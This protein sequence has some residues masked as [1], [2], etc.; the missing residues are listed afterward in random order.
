MTD[1]LFIFRE[2]CG[3]EQLIGFITSNPGPVFSYDSEYLK[4]SNAKPIS[5]SL[6]LKQGEFT[7]KETRSFFEG[8]L[9]EGELRTLFA[10]TL[11]VEPE[12]YTK[13]ISQLNNESTGA[14]I[15]SKEKARPLSNQSYLPLE[16]RTLNEFAKQPKK[17][18]L[19]LGMR[20]RLSL[21]G[22]QAK[23]GLYHEG[24]D[25]SAG[26]F[27]PIGGAPSTHILKASDGTFPM[28]TINEAFC[29]R[30]AALCGLNVCESSLIAVKDSSD[31]ILI[32]ERFDR[33]RAERSRREDGHI[34]PF[35]LH[36]EDFCQASSL[37][38]MYK[39][40]PTDG[41]Y[42]SRVAHVIGKAS[43][44]PLEDRLKFFQGILFDYLIGNC[45]NHLKNYSLLWTEDWS[46][47]SLSPFYDKTCTTM[48]P[49]L[50]REMGISL[51]PSRVI[52]KVIESDIKASG[53]QIG[54]SESMS[55]S[56]YQKL[57]NSFSK[58]L[59]QA[60]LEISNQ[61]FPE[62]KELAEFIY[63]DAE[64]RLT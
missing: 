63:L 32:I 24:N 11:H 3:D 48:Y 4:N 6:P 38:S 18:T 41:Y 36:Q 16:S 61:G 33:V 7:Q 44:N 53:K 25:L 37:P 62:V 13:L 35:R 19:E 55:W 40:E 1:T 58:A 39:Y 49:V 60:E 34:V 8:L 51:S 2:Y 47:C 14:L 23:I 30:V 28:Q 12:A 56:L 42:L 54:I 20:T 31:P 15:F 46:S 29:L 26:W 5:Q 50:A 21:A 10:D 17:V 9:P 45:D 64:K 57:R 22:A 59:M 43:F 52:D 27:I